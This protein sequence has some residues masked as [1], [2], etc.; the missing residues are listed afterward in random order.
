MSALDA[1][2]S[3]MLA[4]Q[5]RIDAVGNNIANAGTA[6]Y[7][8]SDVL[9]ADALYQV[10]QPATAPSG[11][12]GGTDPTAIGQGVVVSGTNSD[13]S[14]GS[15]MAT[16]RSTDVAIEGDGFLTVT[17]GSNIYYTRNGSLG[18]DANGN[19]VSLATGMRVV[20]LPAS[21]AAAAAGSASGTP[22][23]ASGGASGTPPPALAITPADTLQVPLGQTSIAR[24]TTQ[25]AMGGNL[26][27]RAAA[28]TNYQ[29]TASVYDSLG[30]PHDVT[31]TFTRSATAGQ[32]TAAAT[33]PDG[34]VAFTPAAPVTFDAN[35]APTTKSLSMQMTLSNANG[36]NA[37]ITANL[38]LANVTQLA[39][40][41]GAAVRTQDGMPPGTLTGIA[42]ETDGT[43]MG[44]FTNGV[45]SSLGQ[46]VTGTFS[47]TSGLLNK[48]DSLYQ[49]STNSGVAAYGPPGSN[50][51]GLIR[52]GQ[53]EQS[54]VNLTQEFSDMIVTERAYQANSRVVNTAD[55][56]LQQLMSLSQ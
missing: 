28:G 25:V 10:I 46:L 15:L 50:G 35:G 22:P 52:S 19:L 9:F 21:G 42:I 29:I 20:A 51:R 18:L 24:A 48:G 36:A 8:S 6:G 16:G 2:V 39:Q 38:S 11:T 31:V 47:N 37:S 54:N 40:D 27:S 34:T 5:I 32:W 1:G 43:V 26:D 13:F 12:T 23:P 55:Q 4:D 7:K 17:D 49:A 3:G 45:K 30:A 14:Q 33:S 41:S 56:M 53:L 44:V